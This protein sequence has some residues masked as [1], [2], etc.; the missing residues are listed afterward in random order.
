MSLSS[1][2]EDH[3]AKPCIKIAV[4][5]KL[6]LQRDLNRNE[7]C[8]EHMRNLSDGSFTIQIVEHRVVGQRSVAGQY[9]KISGDILSQDTF[10]FIFV[11]HLR[12][13]AA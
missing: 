1:A 6:S 7:S 12:G 13:C 9:C 10:T 4:N 2:V 11:P 8:K 3:D 5:S